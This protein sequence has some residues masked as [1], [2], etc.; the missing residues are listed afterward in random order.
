MINDNYGYFLLSTEVIYS[1]ING[2]RTCR[3]VSLVDETCFV[4]QVFAP[5]PRL[6]GVGPPDE[7]VQIEPMH[8][9]EIKTEATSLLPVTVPST[10]D[11][12]FGSVLDRKT[13]SGA[14]RNQSIDGLRTLLALK[15]VLEHTS[16]THNLLWSHSL[17]SVEKSIVQ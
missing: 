4:R 10:T 17:P 8:S 14:A 11:K 9:K 2:S 7:R 1:Y 6:M 5:S 15:V 13:A 12:A 3:T 16:F